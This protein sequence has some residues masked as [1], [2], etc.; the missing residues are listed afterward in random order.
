VAL[1]CRPIE[2]QAAAPVEV[3]YAHTKRV[4]PPH[5]S[6]PLAGPAHETVPLAMPVITTAAS[7]S[8]RPQYI[9]AFRA[10]TTV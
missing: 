9:I 5:S 2:K 6:P 4:T 8:V 10:N 7:N 3:Q 1:D